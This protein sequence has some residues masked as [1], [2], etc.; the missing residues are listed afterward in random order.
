MKRITTAALV[1]LALTGWASGQ[2]PGSTEYFEKYI[3][4]VL[5]TKC[6]ECHSAEHEV[7]GGLAL[8]SKPAW[9]QGGDSGPAIEPGQPDKSR[10]I[11][12]HGVRQPK[13]A[14]AT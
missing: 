10:M 11:E 8:D 13:L 1:L 5:V 6:L 14:N 7:S 9:E 12:G 3:R 4:P 2:D